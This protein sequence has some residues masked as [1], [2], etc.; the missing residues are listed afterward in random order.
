MLIA[1]KL[2]GPKEDLLWKCPGAIMYGSISECM[3]FEN[4]HLKDFLK[5]G[6]AFMRFTDPGKFITLLICLEYWSEKTWY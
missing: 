1:K 3:T 2:A 5:R 4:Y 6:I